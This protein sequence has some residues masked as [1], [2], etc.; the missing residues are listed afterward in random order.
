MLIGRI[1]L[2]CLLRAAVRRDACAAATRSIVPSV[3]LPQ[4]HNR[5]PE[6]LLLY[7]LK[8][9][10]HAVF[11]LRRLVLQRREYVATAKS[12]LKPKPLQCR[13]CFAASACKDSSKHKKLELLLDL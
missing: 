9:D 13:L 4:L 6:E 3:A 1:C 10:T 2:I 11:E 7:A 5:T 8:F 12:T